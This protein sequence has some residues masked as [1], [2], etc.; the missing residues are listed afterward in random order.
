MYK[1]SVTSR[2]IHM[3]LYINLDKNNTAFI[4]A[5]TTTTLNQANL[6]FFKSRDL[7]LF[8]FASLAYDTVHHICCTQEIFVC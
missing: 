4:S 3:S 2:I 6:R 5:P 8:I 7:F 1:L